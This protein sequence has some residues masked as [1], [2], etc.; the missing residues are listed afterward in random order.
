VTE[1][2]RNFI[3]RQYVYDAHGERNEDVHSFDE[4]VT[5]HPRANRN[6]RLVD[7]E[8][9]NVERPLRRSHG[10]IDGEFQEIEAA[11]TDEYRSLNQT[12]ALL[13]KDFIL[14]D[15]PREG[16]AVTRL[17][18][19][20]SPVAGY[21]GRRDDRNGLVEIYDAEGGNVVAR[22]RHLSGIAVGVGDTVAYGQSLGTQ[23]NVGLGLQPGVGIHVH[24]EMDTG[25]FQHYEN[26]MQ[27]LTDGRLP[28]QASFREGVEPLPV[29][30]DNVARLGE[31]SDRVRDVQTAL[32]AD[33]Y[34]ATGDRPIEI[35]G[36]YRPEIQGAVIAFQQDHGP[37]QTGD[38]DQATWEQAVDI[39]RRLGPVVAPPEEPPM[40]RGPMLDPL[41]GVNQADLAPGDP[42]FGL[43]PASDPARTG[44]VPQWDEHADHTQQRDR[45]GQNIQQQ[46]PDTQR[47][48]ERAQPQP[49][50][51][52]RMPAPGGREPLER[53]NGPELPPERQG[54][55]QRQGIL[56]LDNP[57][58]E[59]HAMYE[60]LL[61]VVNERDRELGREPDD[62][63]RQLAGG[64]VE[65]ARERG[66]DTIGAAKFTPDGIKVGMTDT[67]ELSSPW[68]KTAV[69]DVGQLA[70]QKLSQ[71]SENVAAINQQLALEQ[72]LKQPSQTQSMAGPEESAP[73]GLRLA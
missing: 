34:L 73:K 38:I 59:N 16:A 63:S 7:G 40:M 20:P 65:K 11:R 48:E 41:Q 54:P 47:Q 61:R 31:S 70:G 71:S 22:V 19:V 35:N 6:A 56:M 67:A 37:L 13:V 9:Q 52:P 50:G 24:L 66:L 62:V 68:A 44:R 18:D 25:Y 55:P 69:G 43:L 26:Y 14:E 42:R 39:N 4:L 60:T 23:G 36:V 8:L 49:P 58:H 10:F 27:D 17:I 46:V 2:P 1:T 32:A 3:V 12:Q 15:R 5:H 28:V 72:S 29:I 21:V 64:L 30:D 45:S 57:L 53:G 33:G 51:D